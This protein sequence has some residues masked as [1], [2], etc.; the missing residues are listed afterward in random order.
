MP[1]TTRTAA[2]LALPL[3]AGALLAPATSLASPASR[4]QATALAKDYLRSSAFSRKG[5]AEQLR[6]EG[7]SGYDAAWGADHSGANWYRQAV[8]E[9]RSYLRSSHFSHSGLVG[10]LVYEGFTAAQAQYGVRGVGL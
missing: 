9:A 3:V 4:A 6:Y 2:L 8:L 5:L 7:F 10:Q 1:R